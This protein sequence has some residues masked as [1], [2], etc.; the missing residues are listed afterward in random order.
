MMCEKCGS[1]NRRDFGA[2][3][4]IHFPGLENLSTPHLLVF[5]KLAVCLDC[6]ASEFT[7]PET[8]LQL[9]KKGLGKDSEPTSSEGFD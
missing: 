7:L 3:V 4:C 6:G 8:E 9:L 5:P 1:V 2:E